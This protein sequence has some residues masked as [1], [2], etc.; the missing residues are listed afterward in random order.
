MT[1]PVGPGRRRSSP[2]FDAASAV[3]RPSYDRQRDKSS[4]SSLQP[5]NSTLSGG[6]QMTGTFGMQRRN[7]SRPGQPWYR[8]RIVSQSFLHGVVSAPGKQRSIALPQISVQVG[9]GVALGSDGSLPL[10]A[11]ASSDVRPPHPKVEKT[12]SAAHAARVFAILFM[13]AFAPPSNA[14]RWSGA[15]H[16]LD[17]RLQVSCRTQSD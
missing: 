4:R 2:R 14:E 13:D 1:L 6:E 12:T 3:A 9:T 15:R 10:S 5:L 7:G 8:L 16:H 17:A 11:P